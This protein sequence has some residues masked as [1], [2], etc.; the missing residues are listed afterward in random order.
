[1]T[2]AYSGVLTR[3]DA[4]LRILEVLDAEESGPVERL[5]LEGM[6]YMTQQSGYDSKHCRVLRAFDGDDWRSGL[7][8]SIAYLQQMDR[9]KH[10]AGHYALTDLGEERLGEID[11]PPELDADNEETVIR[12]LAQFVREG[13]SI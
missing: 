3:S 4:V 13:L 11:T 2:A 9:V 12:S 6:A 10:S 7:Y 8:K 1:M 5:L